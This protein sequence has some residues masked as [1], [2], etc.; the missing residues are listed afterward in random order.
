[1]APVWLACVNDPM[2]DFLSALGCD[3]VTSNSIVGAERTSPMVIAVLLT[4]SLAMI[5]PSIMIKLWPTNRLGSDP[6]DLLAVA[7]WMRRGGDARSIRLWKTD[8]SIAGAMVIGWCRP[9]RFLLLSD[10]LIEKLDRDELRMVILHEAAHCK[11]WHAWLRLLPSRDHASANA[12][13]SACTIWLSFT[14]LA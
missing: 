9:F 2:R 4:M 13:C 5:V 3:D 6:K 7:A 14:L 8:L 11:R 1:M 10:L 12:H